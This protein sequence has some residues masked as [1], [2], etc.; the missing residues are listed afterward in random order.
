[1]LMT[2]NGFAGNSQRVEA[3]A[4]IVLDRAEKVL[5]QDQNNGMAIGYS[6][7]GLAALGE[8]ERAKERMTRALLIEP[9]NWSMHYNFACTLIAAKDM[10]GAFEMLQL[11]FAKFPPGLVNHAKVDPDLDAIRNDPRFKAMMAAADARLAEAK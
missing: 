10:D 1:M 5:A 9:E 11:S 2:C 6:A 4:R 7:Y 8:V 3:A